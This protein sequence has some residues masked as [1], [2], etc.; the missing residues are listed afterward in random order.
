MNFMSRDEEVNYFPSRC[1]RLAV[2]VL[3]LRQGA[4]GASGASVPDARPALLGMLRESS[5]PHTAAPLHTHTH[6]RTRTRARTPTRHPPV[7]NI[8]LMCVCMC[9]RHICLQV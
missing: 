2:L 4:S 7:L 6:A 8:Q 3:V 5:G 1:M 9:A